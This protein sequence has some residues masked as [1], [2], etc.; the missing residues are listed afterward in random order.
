MSWFDDWWRRK[1]RKPRDID[2]FDRLFDEI[3]REF[4]KFFG[5]VGGPVV[6]GF[7]ITIGP[8]GKPIFREFGPERRLGEE[9]EVEVDVIDAKDHYDII[10]DMPGLNEK[11][12]D[13]EFREGKLVLKGKGVRSYYKVVDLPEDV[14][15]RIISK[16][17]FNGV[18]TV[19][20]PKKKGLRKIL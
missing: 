9:R 3:L 2:D 10:A 11:D 13:V 8:D 18:L 17:Y 12:I 20:I 16:R 5:G 14:A 6:R 7:S 4:E 19:R 15:Q 1:G